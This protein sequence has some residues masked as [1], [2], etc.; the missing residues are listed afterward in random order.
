MLQTFSDVDGDWLVFSQA[1]TV[2][3]RRGVRA[4]RLL[5]A[6]G[7]RG[8][9]VAPRHAGTYLRHAG[10]HTGRR[11]FGI[12]RHLRTRRRPAVAPDLPAVVSDATS[13]PTR[14]PSDPRFRCFFGAM[15]APSREPAWARA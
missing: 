11:Q 4:A 15:R 8:A 14:A 12:G 6:S 2:A 5:K 1:V 7:C 9:L 10:Q 13:R 3:P